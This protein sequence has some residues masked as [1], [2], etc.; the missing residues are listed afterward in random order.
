[1]ASGTGSTLPLLRELI[2][3]Y[4]A[5]GEFDKEQEYWNRFLKTG[6]RLKDDKEKALYMR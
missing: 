3:A 2:Q 5:A 4:R 6:E 1:M